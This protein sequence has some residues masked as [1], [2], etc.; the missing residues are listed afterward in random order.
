[1][2]AAIRARRGAMP[3]L[4]LLPF[5]AALAGSCTDVSTGPS[6]AVAIEFDTLPFPAVVTG[7]TL[8]DS[9]G[10]VA[11]LHA[12][13]YNASGA[14]IANAGV[15]YITLD[16]GL[17]IDPM[18]I[19]TAQLRNGP[20]RLVASVSGLQS[21]TKTLEVARRPDSVVVTGKLSDTLHYALP[22][23]PATNVSAG[24][25]LKLTTRDTAGGVAVTR[26]WLV[27]Y[28]A[29]FRGQ[30]LVLSDTTVASLWS[31]GT[32]PSALD[33]TGADG[34]ASRRIRVRPQAPGFT[35]AESLIVIA[36]VR[37]RGAPVRGSPVRFV[38]HTR[39]K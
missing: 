12:L 26:G 6:R 36:T 14:P 16:T 35:A 21:V 37:Y 38:I 17:T 24:L 2:T 10:L 32:K 25:G 3:L 15:T 9:L 7:D 5:L 19:V 31:D 28:Q 1:M 4:P 34:A 11:P 13:A 29:F 20:V 22:D 30:A 8:R 33:T 18:G 39:P 23:N 27:S